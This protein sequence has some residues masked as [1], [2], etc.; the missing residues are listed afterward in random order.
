VRFLS[1]LPEIISVR[2]V[3]TDYSGYHFTGV[4]R[5]FLKTENVQHSTGADVYY[6][7][8]NNPVTTESGTFAPFA[9]QT[10]DIDMVPVHHFLASD[11]EDTDHAETDSFTY[12]G[13]P[14][15]PLPICNLQVNNQGNN[16]HVTS[17]DDAN[18]S[19]RNQSRDGAGF[20]F[21][22]QQKPQDPTPDY[23]QIRFEVYDGSTLVR[24]EILTGTDD[25]YSY[26]SAMQSSDGVL[27]KNFKVKIT[28]RNSV[29]EADT[30]ELTVTR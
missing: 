26:T 13:S 9:N 22:D 30:V 23:D 12:K 29:C 18:F 11:I 14:F 28:P 3:T 5:G 19:W 2:D 15:R 16:T 24:S 27:S 25:S 7:N 4:I 8:F 10:L 17:G 20:H 6:L 21:P 1:R